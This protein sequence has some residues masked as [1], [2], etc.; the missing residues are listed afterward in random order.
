MREIS[1]ATLAI[2]KSQNL[3]GQNRFS[4][5][6]KL[7]G[8]DYYTDIKSSFETVL[9]T[10]ATSADFVIRADGKVLVVYSIGLDI[11]VSYLNSEME[12]MIGDNGSLATNGV[13]FYTLANGSETNNFKLLKLK[14]GRILLFISD[15][16]LQSENKP[17]CIKV[18]ESINGLGT[19]FA[20]LSTMF[21]KDRSSTD[22]R[23]LHNTISKP[24]QLNNG[25]ICFICYRIS[26]IKVDGYEWG[27]LAVYT[28]DNYGLTWAEKYVYSFSFSM[29]VWFLRLQMSA[30][31]FDTVSDQGNFIMVPIGER[32]D[33][34]SIEL[35]YSIDGGNTFSL[36]WD[37]NVL[38]NVFS[39]QNEYIA[40]FS[41]ASDGYIYLIRTTSAVPSIP[42]NLYRAKI[43]ATGLT[44]EYLNTWSNWEIYAFGIKTS[45]YLTSLSMTPNGIIHNLGWDGSSITDFGYVREPYS[46]SLNVSSI[47]INKGKGGSNTAAIQASNKNGT[48]NPKNSDGPLYNILKTNKQIIIKQGYGEEMVETFTGMIDDFDMST[49]P[50]TTGISLRDNLKKALDQTITNGTQH[51]VEFASQPIENIVG[52]LCYLANIEVGVDGIEA[53]GISVAMSFSWCSYADAFQQ[54]GDLASF[55]WG[56]DSYGKF[57]FRRDYQP[58]NMFVAYTFEEGVDLATLKYKI[59]DKDLYSKVVVFGKSGDAV[60]SYEAPFLDAALYNILPQKI[61]KIDA[62]EAS[63]IGVLR[64]IAER[65]LSSMQSRTAVIQFTSIAIPWLEPGDFIGI[66]ER[67]TGAASIYRLSDLSFNMEKDSFTM[68]GT[69][70]YYGDSIVPGE[71]PTDTATQVVAPTVNLIPEMTSNIAPSGVARASSIYTSNYEPWQAFNNHSDDYYWN[72]ITNTGWIEYQFPEK[73]IVDKYMLKARQ[74]TIYNDA[75]PRDWT[76]EGFDGEKWVV[77]D[78]Q[79]GQTNWGVYQSRTYLFANT[80]AYSKYR[81]NVSRNDGYIRLQLEQLAMYYG[82]GA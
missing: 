76:F 15:M 1:E 6:L 52:Y 13:L 77:L 56:C 19:D 22:N 26:E 33:G 54:L 72:S 82:G 51:T 47:S 59:S 43:P 14:N 45:F 53:T 42:S 74:L 34:A 35:M 20:L 66:Y 44:I 65:A 23:C 9:K 17:F 40:P 3:T 80:T 8:V 60:I 73:M 81:L 2:L 71:L 24:I 5:S 28:S 12:M 25:K 21:T 75:M 7:E 49:W 64:K 41:I 61:L 79:T 10:S 63:T 55:E 29:G 67:S 27:E 62:T 4:H 38:G 16:G 39:M 68:G 36:I 46:E 48:L 31:L 50:Q 70:Y 32:Y 69:A 18:Y 58:D 37:S 30:N 57:Y 78:R 11:Y